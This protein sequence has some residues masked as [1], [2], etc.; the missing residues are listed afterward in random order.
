MNFVN[1][2]T[3]IYKKNDTKAAVII[4]H[5][6]I[7]IYMKNNTWSYIYK[8]QSINIASLQIY[9]LKDIQPCLI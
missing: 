1:R 8:N 7:Y 6:I 9:V 3:K 2:V 4:G 5:Y